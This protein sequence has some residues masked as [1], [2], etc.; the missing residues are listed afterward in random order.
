MPQQVHAEH[1][2]NTAVTTAAARLEA[3]DVEYTLQDLVKAAK[4]DK[5]AVLDVLKRNWVDE[6]HLDIVYLNLT[7]DEE[8]LLYS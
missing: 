4:L 7:R 8:A 2:P 5:A 1:D 3:K 6:D